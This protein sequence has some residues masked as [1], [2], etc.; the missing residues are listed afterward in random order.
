ME[1]TWS[2]EYKKIKER[3]ERFATTKSL[4]LNDPV[5]LK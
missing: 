5:I 3:E 2:E 4:Q 1:N